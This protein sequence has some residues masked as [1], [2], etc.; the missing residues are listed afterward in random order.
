MRYFDPEIEW[1]TTG[2]FFE[3]VISVRISGVGKRSGAPVDLTLASVCSLRDGKL[4][5]IVNCPEKAEAL[6][7]V[8]LPE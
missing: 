8:G 5:R 6:E 3:V 4:F 2:T 7:A 1:T